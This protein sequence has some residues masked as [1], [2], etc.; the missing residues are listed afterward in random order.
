MIQKENTQDRGLRFKQEEM[1]G[2]ESVLTFWSKE[3]L[4]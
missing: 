2:L 1:L 4:T 3:C